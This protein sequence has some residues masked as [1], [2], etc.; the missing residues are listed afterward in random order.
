MVRKVALAS[1]LLIY[2][3]QLVSLSVTHLRSI[4]YGYSE[5]KNRHFWRFLW[6]LSIRQSV[7]NCLMLGL[8]FIINH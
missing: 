8:L 4:P 7:S 6:V 1:K 5:T 3:I 2:L